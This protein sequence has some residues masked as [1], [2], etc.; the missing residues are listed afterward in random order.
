MDKKGQPA[1]L[2]DRQPLNG[3]ALGVHG[4]RQT[5]GFTWIGECLWCCQDGCD[6][7]LARESTCAGMSDNR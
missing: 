6:P 7:S 5:K 3:E 4:V 2:A 1:G